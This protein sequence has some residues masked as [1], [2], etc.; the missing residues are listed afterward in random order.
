MTT[1]LPW[2][3]DRLPTE[4]DGD[5]DGDVIGLLPCGLTWY[6]IHWGEIVPDQPWLPFTPPGATP[7]P[8]APTSQRRIVSLTRTVYGAVHTIDAVAD[9]GTA[10]WMV[11]GEVEWTQ[12]PALPKREDDP[13]AGK[14]P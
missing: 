1:P 12:L 5:N 13:T 2:I 3:T 7:E 6:V 14:V 4:A 8:T 9:D 11:P 10:W